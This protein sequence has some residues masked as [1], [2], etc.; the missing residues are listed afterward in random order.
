MRA[1]TCQQTASTSG[2]DYL[3]SLFRFAKRKF[4]PIQPT[5]I[6]TVGRNRPIQ[7]PRTVWGSGFPAKNA[8]RLAIT[9]FCIAT[10][11][12]SV[13]PPTCGVSTTFGKAVS[14]S[15]GVRLHL[16]DVETGA[17]DRLLRQ[18]CDQRLL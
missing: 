9:Q 6:L 11:D 17:C 14:A 16:V 4:T 2:T 10:C 7:V 12:S 3:T 1:L 15:G 13:W 18:R 8:S 5:G